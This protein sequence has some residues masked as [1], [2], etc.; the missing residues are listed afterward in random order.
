MLSNQCEILKAKYWLMGL[1]Q[2]EIE[3]RD[4]AAAAS[5]TCNS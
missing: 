1:P 5:I 3:T 2:G 4:E